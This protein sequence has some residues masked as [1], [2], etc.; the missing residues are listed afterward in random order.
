MRA[1]LC[2]RSEGHQGHDDFADVLIGSWWVVAAGVD[3]ELTS[4]FV[5]MGAANVDKAI[6]RIC[7]VIAIGR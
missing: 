4:L 3:F 2:L 6:N 5:M 7:L 1:L